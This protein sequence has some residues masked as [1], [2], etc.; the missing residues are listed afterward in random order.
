M[1]IGAIIRGWRERQGIGLRAVADEIGTSPAT[2]SR[3]ELGDSVDGTT[4][5][6]LMFW[7]FGDKK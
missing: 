6:K 2:L 3:L 5:V 4:M 7:L 1:R